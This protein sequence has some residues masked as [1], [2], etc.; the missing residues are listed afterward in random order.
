MFQILTYVIKTLGLSNIQ[1][2]L[3]CLN[4]GQERQLQILMDIDE[5]DRLLQPS[6]TK[7]RLIQAKS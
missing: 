3:C 5:K 2:P 4:T 6:L 1:H 7:D